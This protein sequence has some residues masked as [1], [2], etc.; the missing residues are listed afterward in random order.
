MEC[1]S[2]NGLRDTKTLYQWKYDRVREVILSVLPEG[3][4]GMPSR[5]WLRA[6]VVGCVAWGTVSSLW[7]YPHSM[8]YFNELAGGPRGGDRHLINSNIEW[9]QDLFFLRDKLEQMGWDRVGMVY[10][11]RYDARLGGIDFHLPPRGPLESVSTERGRSRLLPAPGRYAISVNQLHGYAFVAPD[12]RGGLTMPRRDAYRYFQRWEPVASAGYSMRLYDVSASDISEL[13]QDLQWDGLP[14][15]ELT[16]GRE[17]S[18]GANPA[19]AVAS[20]PGE[21]GYLVGYADGSVRRFRRSEA[22]RREGTESGDDRRGLDSELVGTA[23]T[24]VETI[25]CAPTGD[26]FATADG[27]G[28]LDVASIRPLEETASAVAIGVHPGRV[29]A[30]AFSPDGSRL[31]SAGDDGNV[32][33]WSGETLQS[34]DTSLSAE[35]S[36]SEGRL[37]GTLDCRLPATALAWLGSDGIVVGTG[38]WRTGRRGTIRGYDLAGNPLAEMHESRHFIIDVV[39]TAEGHVIGRGS[40]GELSI[41][42]GT[43]WHGTTGEKRFT[44]VGEQ[45]RPLALSDDG[46]WLVAGDS[47]GVIRLW[48]LATGDLVYESREFDHRIADVAF[49]ETF[50]DGMTVD[51]ARHCVVAVD[52]QGWLREFSIQ[53][54]LR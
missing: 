6:A 11:G 37:L 52:D 43:I 3:E 14:K 17:R 4:E 47:R 5:R 13:R 9:G 38:D 45:P 31:A 18:P 23:E 20:V 26:R 41:W 32:R 33:I 29:H 12:G 46:R 44:L 30:I 39:T 22:T 35:A 27:N 50:L 36:E 53:T 48:E 7:T 49:A 8:S 28:R 54:V 51:G 19:R 10:W 2:P 15:V 1:R 16:I 40:R 21:E 34:L 42:H 25:A 24:R